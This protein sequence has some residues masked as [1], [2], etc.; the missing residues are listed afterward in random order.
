MVL[1][2]DNYSLHCVNE[3]RHV[4]DIL[5]AGINIEA[6][7]CVCVVFGLFIFLNTTMTVL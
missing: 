5:K 3:K 6:K 1:Q 2:V 7:E 4:C